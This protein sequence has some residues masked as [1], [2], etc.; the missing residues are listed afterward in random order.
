[1]YFL[2]FWL[3]IIVTFYFIADLCQLQQFVCQNSDFG[4]IIEMYNLIIMI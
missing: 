2:S 3:I 1:M 4:M